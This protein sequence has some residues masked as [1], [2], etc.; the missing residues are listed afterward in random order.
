MSLFFFLSKYD[1]VLA[2]DIQAIDKQFGVGFGV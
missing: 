1:C 2:N